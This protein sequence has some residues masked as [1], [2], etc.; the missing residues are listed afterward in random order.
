MMQF[1]LPVYTT[2]SEEGVLF[3]L[4]LLNNNKT[5]HFNGKMKFQTVHLSRIENQ[6]TSNPIMEKLRLSRV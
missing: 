5:V 1:I 2:R 6:R 3:V 4:Q